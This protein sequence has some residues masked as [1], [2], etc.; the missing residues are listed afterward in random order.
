MVAT[1]GE[2]EWPNYSLSVSRYA[3]SCCGYLTLEEPQRGNYAI[4][5]VCFWEDDPVQLEDA[6]FKGGANVPSLSE[7]RETFAAIGLGFRDEFG[8]RSPASTRPRSPSATTPRAASPDHCS[9]SGLS[10]R[11]APPDH[12]RR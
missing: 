8:A 3:C 11:V 12:L 2:V 7:A 9:T 4:C 5:P 6:D 1:R 10:A